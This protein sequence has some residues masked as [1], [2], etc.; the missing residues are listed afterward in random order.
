MADETSESVPYHNSPQDREDLLHRIARISG[1]VDG[2]R[3]MIQDQ[4]YCIDL[5]NQIHSVRRALD[6][7]AAE[8]MEEHLRGCV[9]DAIDSNDPYEEQEKLSEFM[10]TVRDFLKK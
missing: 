4:A 7:L 8:I 2:V 9:R 5:I 1:Q 6:G 10:D 3:N